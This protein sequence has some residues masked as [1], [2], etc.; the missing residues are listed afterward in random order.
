MIVRKNIQDTVPKAIM[1]F[2]VNHVKDQLQSELVAVLYNVTSEENEDLLDE[3]VEITRKRREAQQM[4]DVRCLY[5]SIFHCESFLIIFTRLYKKQAKSYQKFVRLNFGKLII[6]QC[7]LKYISKY[8]C[9]CLF[10]NEYM[11]VVFQ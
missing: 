2:L 10:F 1:H 3:S 5:S 9:L 4:L 11:L 8:I 7:S 6:R